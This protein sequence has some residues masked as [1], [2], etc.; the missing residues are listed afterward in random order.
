MTTD[1]VDLCTPFLVEVQTNA[2]DFCAACA[3][4]QHGDLDCRLP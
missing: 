1:F 2:S 4:W 3:K